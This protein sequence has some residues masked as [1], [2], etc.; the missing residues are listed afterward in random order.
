MRDAP[1]LCKEGYG[2]SCP[3]DVV[4]GVGVDTQQIPFFDEEGNAQ[5]EAGLKGD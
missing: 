4:A 2:R 1:F 3:F 5:L